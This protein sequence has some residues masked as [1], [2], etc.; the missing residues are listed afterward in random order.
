MVTL[1]EYEGN[2]GRRKKQREE[3]EGGDRERRVKYER[4]RTSRI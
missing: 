4:E 3:R 2:R 1:K